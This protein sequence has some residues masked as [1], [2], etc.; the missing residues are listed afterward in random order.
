M[1]SLFALPIAAGFPQVIVYLALAG[2]LAAA[3]AALASSLVAIAAIL[4]EDIVHG[5]PDE[6]APDARPHRHGARRPAGGGLRDAPGWPSRRRPTR[7]S[8]SCGR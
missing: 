5:L 6:T 4:A 8:C 7:C 1:R 3:L 2:A